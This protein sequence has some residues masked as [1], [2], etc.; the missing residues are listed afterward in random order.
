MPPA[1]SDLP[2]QQTF[3]PVDAREVAAALAQ[4]HQERTPVYPVGGGTSLHYGLP[5]T[6]PG[7]GLSLGRLDQ[8][9]DYPARDM[10]ITLGSGVTLKRLA[11][12][13]AQ[14]RQQ[15]PWDVPQADRA[16]LGG[17]VATN[18]NGHRRYGLGSVRD[19]VI[20]IEAVDGRGMTFHGGGRV[21]KNVAGY[22]FCKL[23]TGSFGTLGVITQLTLKLRPLPERSTFAVARVALDDA[24]K[25]LAALVGSSTTPVAIELLGGPA[26]SDAAG[27][28]GPLAAGETRL[29]VGLEGT[30][31][32]VAWM[33]QQLAREWRS[34]G[35]TSLGV[36][37]DSEVPALRERIVEFSAVASPL[38]IKGVM[39]P[40]GLV[41]F[42]RA[43]REIDPACSLQL[44]AGNGIAFVRFSQLPAGGLTGSLIGRLQPLAAAAHGHVTV[45][46]NPSAAEMTSQS[47]WDAGGAPVGLM[48]EVKKQFDPHH[49][50]NPGRFVV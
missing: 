4:A 26:W 11:D 41:A 47:V 49:I 7:I 20:G 10:T 37:A 48:Q 28:A 22:D 6:R 5:A 25:A 27:L 36:V 32:E 38:V 40:S 34:Q 24:E 2:L 15:L 35:V 3:E 23:L 45:L 31:A 43:A 17:I 12:V 14:E 9:V 44:H 42:A 16:T 46:C 50:L 13:L 19:Y 29:V 8:I 39:A 30:A 21:V 33:S 18:W 1:K